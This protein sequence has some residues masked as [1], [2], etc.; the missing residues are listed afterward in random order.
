MKLLL[1]THI[2]AF[3]ADRPKRLG[4]RT[5]KLLADRRNEIWLSS[6]S[7][8]EVILLQRIGRL[9]GTGSPQAWI[10][11]TVAA[12][13]LRET[14]LTSAM[15]IEASFITLPTKDPADCLLVATAR[16]LGCRMVTE[17]EAIKDSKLVDVIP[18]D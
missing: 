5:A 9:R 3:M 2:W 15:A 14:P 7:V 18:N 11:T 6:L 12:W 8:W 1:D 13:G 4:P 10:E 16:I 17:D